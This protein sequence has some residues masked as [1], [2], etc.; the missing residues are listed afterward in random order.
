MSLCRDGG[1]NE[2]VVILLRTPEK[3]QTIIPKTEVYLLQRRQRKF[4]VQGE[5]IMNPLIEWV[6]IRTPPEIISFLTWLLTV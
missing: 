6:I 3:I 5:V 1:E 2:L 4:R